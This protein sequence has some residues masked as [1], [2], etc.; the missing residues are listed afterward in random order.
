MITNQTKFRPV[1]GTEAGILDLDHHEGWVYVASDTGKIF[2]DANNQRKQI[3]GSGGSS[4]GGSA[5]LVWGFADEDQNTLKEDPNDTSGT[6][7]MYL[8]SL[9]A[10]EGGSIP[11][12]DALILNSDGRFFRVLDNTI[13]VDRFFSVEL[14]AVSGGGGGGGGTSS[15]DLELT[16]DSTTIMTGATLIQG[17]DYNIRIVGTSTKDPTVSLHIEFTG[18]NGYYWD[19]SYINPSGIE[20]LFNTKILPENSNLTMKVTVSSDNTEMRRLPSRSVSGIKVIPMTISKSSTLNT[21]AAMQGSA[22]VPYYLGGD[23]DLQETLHV[24]IDGNENF[25]L[26]QTVYP[27]SSERTVLIPPQGHGTHS[28]ELN[29]STDINGVTIYSDSIRYELAWIDANESDP[30]IWVQ[31]Y[32]KTVIRY[33]NFVINY[34]VYDPAASGGG[35]DDYFSVNIYKSGALIS[36]VERKYV[37][38]SWLTL[39]L[40]ESYTVG[41]NE[42]TI[43]CGT[44]SKNISFNV[45]TEGSRDLDLVQTE[46]LLINLSATGRSNNEISANRP[47]WRSGTNYEATFNDF[48][49]YSNGWLNDNDG[50][51]S[52]LSVTN[53]A[54]VTIP[55][56]DYSSNP[57]IMYNFNGNTFNYTFECRFRIKNVQEY[58]TLVS[59]IPYY[60]VM[61]NGVKSSEGVDINVI[62]EQGLIIATDDDGNWL[63]DEQHSKKI[64]K[65]DEGVCLKIISSGN[66]FNGLCIGTQEAYFK[67]PE[68]VTSVRYKEDEIINFSVVI[69]RTDRLASIYLNG[70]LSGSIKL[71]TDSSF[72]IGS[73]IVINS[74]YSDIDLY[75]IRFYQYGLTMPDVIHNYISD[76]HDLTLYDQNQLTK[77]NNPTLLSYQKLVEY[78]DQMLEN[79]DIE[80]LSMPYAVF[81]II[82]NATGMSDPNKGTHVSNDDKLPWMKGNNRYCKITFVNPTLDALYNKGEIDADYYVSHSPSYVCIGADINVQGTSSQGYPRRNYKT[83]HKSATGK[84]DAREQTHDDWGWFYTN[85]KFIEDTGKTTFK[86]WQQDNP[87]YGTNKYTWKIDYMESS[88][89]YNTGFANLVGNNIYDKHPLGYYNI[90]GIKME[91]LR[92]SVY[93][94]PV[95]C[96]H[97][98]SKP[99]DLEKIGTRNEDEIYEY[100]GRYNLN[101]DKG[102]DE[103]YGFSLEVEQPYVV[104]GIDEET[105]AEIHPLIADVAECWEMTDNQGTWT[106]FSYPISAQETKFSTYTLDSYDSETGELKDNPHLEVIR[107]YE[108]RYH[109]EGDYIEKV[110]SDENPYDLAGVNEEIAKLGVSEENA[111]KRAKWERIDTIPKMNQ[112]II[113]KWSNW[114]RFVTW[115]DSTDTNKADPERDL[116]EPVEYAVN[117]APSDMTGVTTRVEDSQMYATFTKDTA[118]YRL[119]KFTSEF[120]QHLNLEYCAVYYVMTELLLCYDSRGKNMMMA[121]YGPMRKGGD[122]IWFPIFYDID[123]QLGLNNIGATL[124]DYDTDATL[125]QTFSTPASVL[126]VNFWTCFSD[127]IKNKYV[128]LRASSRLTYENIDGAYLCDPEVFGS[129][130]MEGIR[131]LIAIG[132]DEYYKYVAPSKTGYYNTSGE[133][134]YDNNSYA[135]AVNGDRKLSRELLL[136]N[137]MN[138]MDSCWVAGDYITQALEQKAIIM[139]GNAN[140]MATSDKYLDSNSLS[141]LPS[142]AWAG[143]ELG[144]YP[145]PYLDGTP[146]FEVTPFLKQY[147]VAYNDNQINGAPVKYQGTPVKTFV[148]DSVLDG[149]KKTPGFPEQ[150]IKLPGPDYISSLGDLSTKYLSRLAIPQGKRLLYLDIGSD[151][152][153]YFNGLLGATTGASGA[154]MF[155][156]NDGA[157]ITDASTGTSIPNPN[158]KALLRR[159]NLTQVTE[160]SEA[161]DVSG[162]DKLREFRALGTKIPYALFAEGAPLDAIHLP[163]TV[164]RID[165]TEARNLER[166]LTTKPV[167]FGQDRDTYTG[168]YIEGVT[169]L[170][171]QTDATEVLL[172]RINIKGGALG[173][174]SYTLMMNTI[175]LRDRENKTKTIRLRLNLEDIKWSPYI[176]VEYGTAYNPST[177]YYRLTDHSTFVRYNFESADEWNNLTLNEKIFTYEENEKSNLI[178]SLSFLDKFISDYTRASTSTIPGD[179]SYYTNLQNSIGYPNITGSVYVSNAEGAA[180]KEADITEKYGKIWPKLKIYA[181]NVEEAYIAKFVQRLDNGKDK[182]IE[183]IRYNKTDEV[184]PTVTEKNVTR[185]NYDFRG[186]TLDPTKHTVQDDEVEFLVNAGIIYPKEDYSQLRALTF[187][188][189]QDVFTFYAVFSITSYT[190]H[191]KDP[192]S[193]EDYTSYQANFGTYLQEPDMFFVTDESNIA[194]TERYKF[195]GWSREISSSNNLYTD[196]RLI[197]TIDITKIISQNQDQTFYAVY[198][199]EDCLTNATSGPDGNVDKYFIFSPNS[200]WSDPDP[201]YVI[202]DG[203]SV[204]ARIPLAGKI[205][206]PTEYNGKPVISIAAGGF[207]GKLNGEP[208][209]GYKISHVYF[210]GDTSKLREFSN[211]CFYQA[212]M[213]L[214]DHVGDISVRY[215][216]TPLGLRYIGEGALMFLFEL[217]PMDL[218]VLKVT[219]IGANA[220]YG[221]FARPALN[222][223]LLHFPGSIKTINSRGFFRLF[224]DTANYQTMFIETLQYG[225]PEDPV[226]LTS[227]TDPETY[228]RF[229]DGVTVGDVYIYTVDGTLSPLLTQMLDGGFL[230]NRDGTSITSGSGNIHVMTA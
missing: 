50:N 109:K 143:E 22:P 173:Y 227:L 25:D 20:F 165:L 17:Q 184:H 64:I 159:I 201:Q 156:I 133:L 189:E 139:R 135:Y 83:K 29:V 13:D 138:Y 46:N 203:Y 188:D 38:G 229:G 2:I 111:S 73:E 84:K 93:G 91:G 177:T 168:L 147:V 175:E 204:E 181:A 103:L 6:D 30:I 222:I 52:Y 145:V 108:C 3:G 152:P 67:T 104:S 44:A 66:D 161:L 206:I 8:Y 40:T 63:M 213:G 51:G 70:I 217:E 194:V 142:N 87:N 72:N 113:D 163:K 212:G 150:I 56:L 141:E 172:N 81:E 151:A 208:A 180:I 120:E 55:F 226:E 89:S 118:A 23:P 121:S 80:S 157:T 205:T 144:V 74:D 78:N 197:K 123:T 5:N 187:S 105:G 225:G 49:W 114:E 185:Q 214:D 154:G 85:E 182:E 61:E 215:I 202:S 131:P 170:T 90:P 59:T 71:G 158:R 36:E 37:G 24:F 192:Q 169:D 57:P 186:W 126:W 136:R 166:I 65:K 230:K 97:K 86:K 196:S 14:I 176:T 88:G 146:E 211:N 162:S 115:V 101:Q 191:F 39:D 77:D 10:I 137:R 54:S 94:F 16:I 155:N 119:Q 190:I 122:Y 15:N 7:S 160:L 60:Y 167:V 223:P 99:S 33:E 228:T 193:N 9:A 207:R 58:S 62:K 21:A 140:N 174:D 48:N 209:G 45:T 200:S 219:E 134:L 124:W 198:L 218:S 112:F 164:T 199:K 42:Y 53:G 125:E 220:F 179:V 98:H 79:N 107:H 148:S 224:N 96:F 110:A 76:M 95:L 132:L 75:K 43:S 34:Q 130:A 116:V 32:E 195:M 82:D 31:D 210:E 100:I 127:Y 102:S 221:S 47:I 19:R 153:G 12:V 28:I 1:Y 149:Y 27:S 69:S 35:R 106:S 117:K 68:G 183:T 92:T 171:A 178:T 216:Q 128:T 4:G 18:A 41:P 129:K 26:S 11:D